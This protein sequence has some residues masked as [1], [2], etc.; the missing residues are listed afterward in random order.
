MSAGGNLPTIN[1]KATAK[2]MYGCGD[3]PD[4]EEVIFPNAVELSKKIVAELLQQTEA[5]KNT[6]PITIRKSDYNEWLI[7]HSGSAENPAQG[8][9]SATYPH[10]RD[11]LAST[12]DFGGWIGR[13][14]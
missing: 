2:G 14:A 6:L 9:P 8:F 1:L 12:S 4:L 3:V 10:I 7:K 5:V 11:F 13:C